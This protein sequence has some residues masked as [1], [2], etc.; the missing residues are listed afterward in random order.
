[1]QF[2]DY[3]LMALL[4]MI[5]FF[6][7]VRLLSINSTSEIMFSS[8]TT[9][10]VDAI[11]EYYYYYDLERLPSASHGIVVLHGTV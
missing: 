7:N 11:R 1:M 10:S 6:H 2:L 3:L 8:S 5:T 4:S 9:L